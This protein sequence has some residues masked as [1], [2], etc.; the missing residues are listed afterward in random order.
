M[1]V[2][3]AWVVV[4]R[5]VGVLVGVVDVVVGLVVALAFGVA[6]LEPVV[7]GVADAGATGLIII[8]TGTGVEPVGQLLVVPVLVA[9]LGMGVKVRVS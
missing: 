5:V 2:F 9:L 4:V 6:P 8:E 3:G 1:E 7:L